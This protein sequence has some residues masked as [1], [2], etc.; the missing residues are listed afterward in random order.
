MGIPGSIWE[1]GHCTGATRRSEWG[2]HYSLS[3]EKDFCRLLLWCDISVQKCSC[4]NTVKMVFCRATWRYVTT[5]FVPNLFL[6]SLCQRHADMWSHP[7][8]YPVHLSTSP[9]SHKSINIMV[10]NGWLTSFLFIVNLPPHSWDKAISDS[11]LETPRSRSW[12]W[13]KSK[14]IQSA[15]YHINS[16]PFHLHQSDQ[17]FW[18]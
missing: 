12:M 11:D 18:R 5:R 10:M 7:G 4:Q 1:S 14:V 9:W 3:P 13:S 15:Q 16:P 6:N 2:G 8:H 17:Q